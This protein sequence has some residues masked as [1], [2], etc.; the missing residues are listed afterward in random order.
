MIMDSASIPTQAPQG[1]GLWHGQ[2]SHDRCLI[3][4]TKVKLK[5][6]LWFLMHF[7]HRKIKQN[8]FRISVNHLSHFV[9][10]LSLNVPVLTDP[11]RLTTYSSGDDKTMLLVHS[12]KVMASDHLEET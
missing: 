8:S 7:S 12:L 6:I 5:S 2:L 1:Q 11:Q 9:S 10:P 4:G 3:E